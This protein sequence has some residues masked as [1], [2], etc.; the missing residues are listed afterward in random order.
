MLRVFSCQMHFKTDVNKACDKLGGSFKGKFKKICSKMSIIVTNAEYNEQR[1]CLDEIANLF[2][3]I[4]R[5][6]T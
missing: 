2:S 4:A 5:Q 3:D 1:G 6:V